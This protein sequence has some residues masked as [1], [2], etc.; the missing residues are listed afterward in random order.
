VTY[1]AHQLFG[2]YEFEKE[3]GANQAFQKFVDV[4]LECNGGAVYLLSLSGNR[5]KTG[6]AKT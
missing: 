6:I 2:K 3:K 5:E 1:G 4:S